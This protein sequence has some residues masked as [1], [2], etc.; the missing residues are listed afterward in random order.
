M[1]RNAVTR[2]AG[3]VPDSASRAAVALSP[4]RRMTATAPVPGGVDKAKI[5][6]RF[7]ARYLTESAPSLNH[8]SPSGV[9]R[10]EEVAVRLGLTQLVEQELNRIHRAHR[11]EDA[12]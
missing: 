8:P 11:V 4:E 6:S 9:H 2:G 5:V 1:V 7:M 12:P 3:R 10:V